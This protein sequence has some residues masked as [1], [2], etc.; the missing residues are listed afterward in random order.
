MVIIIVGGGKVGYYLAKT[1]APQ[2]HRL[3]LIEEDAA[4]CQKIGGEL[5]D[6]GVT[7][8]HGDGTSVSDLRDAEV[9]EADVLIAVTGHD[10]N[11]LSACQ[12]GKTYFGIP[13]TI[14]RVNNPKN[15]NVFHSLGVDS[16]VSSTAYIADIIEHEV[17]WAKI[18]RILSQKVGNLR[19]QEYPVTAHSP[20]AG[21]RVAELRLPGGVILVSLIRDKEAIVP[22]GQTQILP[23]D[24]IVAMGSA[25]SMGLLG[26]CLE[27]VKVGEAV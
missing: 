8:I 23:G 12:L 10:Q 24:T 4:M 22:N 11:N 14:A 27:P 2:K 25:D 1:L 6:L 21:K 26:E 20:T 5:S 7:V 3:V 17:D 9:E 18:N 16:V 13:R 19:I 15:I